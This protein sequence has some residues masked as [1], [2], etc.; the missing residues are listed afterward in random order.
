MNLIPYGTLEFDYKALDA[1]N[2]ES[3]RIKNLPKESAVR[4][5][6]LS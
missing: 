6:S 2:R 4:P 5:M 3:K 1:E